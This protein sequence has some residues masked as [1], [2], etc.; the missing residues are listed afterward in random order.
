MKTTQPALGWSHPEWLVAR[1]QKRWG[2]ER[3]AQLLEW[4]NTPPKTFARVN[5]LKFGGA[6][7]GG[8]GRRPNRGTPDKPKA[9]KSTTAA[10]AAHTAAPQNDRCR[11][12]AHPLAR[13]ECGIRFRP[14]RLV[15]RKP[16][17]RIEIASAADFAGQ[18]PARLV[19]RPGPEHA[20]GAVHAR[21]AARRNDSGFLR[22]ARRQN[23]VSSRN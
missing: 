15:R 9:P 11:R 13:R 3:T 10:G 14:V 17:F 7:G 2:A 18:F 21:P 16:G 12:P 5:A 23:D 6:D 19:L 1:W 20:A 8:C 4:N 22:R